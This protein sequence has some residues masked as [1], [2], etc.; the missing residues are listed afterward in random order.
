MLTMITIVAATEGRKPCE[1]K[2]DNYCSWFD[3]YLSSI[4]H[5]RNEKNNG[6]DGKRK[7]NCFFK[8][9]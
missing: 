3:Y 6:T 5:A 2:E 1:E 8:R 4:R 7:T 9:T